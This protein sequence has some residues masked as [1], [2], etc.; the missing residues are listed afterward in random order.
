MR[1]NY[2]RPMLT[3]HKYWLG[4]AGLAHRL[5]YEI[6]I[7]RYLF[8]VAP[9]FAHIQY[10]NQLLYVIVLRPSGQYLFKPIPTS[11]PMTTEN[12][13]PNPLMQQI[14]PESATE[15]DD[16]PEDPSLNITRP[17]DP[18]R[19]RI[20]TIPALI[21]GIIKRIDHDEID[22][23]PEFQRK[24]RLWSL[25]NKSRLIESLL[26][27]IP[28]PVFYVAADDK[29]RWAV[30]DG[31]QRLTTIYDFVKNKFPLHGLEYL[32]Q[33]NDETFQTLPRTFQRRI[34]ETSLAMNLILDGTPEEVMINIFKRINTGGMPLTSQE[35]RNALNKGKV[36]DLL[37]N[38]ARS[39]ELTA[40]ATGP[41]NDGRMGAQELVLR[42]LAFYTQPWQEYVQNNLGLDQF[43]NSAMRRLNNLPANK[44]DEFSLVFRKTMAI[45]HAI[46]DDNAFRKPKSPDGYRSPINRALFEAWGVTLAKLSDEEQAIL[47]GKKQQ[48]R[49]DFT[50]LMANPIFNTAISS[51]T[52]ALARVTTRFTE[53]EHLIQNALK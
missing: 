47:I 50:Q 48:I 5:I 9:F 11:L 23:A 8:A 33:L 6:H 24:A 46:F 21:D 39:A 10:H 36:R 28:L 26:L 15:V 1:R 29:D 37:Q 17:F 51:S 52:G 13:Q 45:S 22:L 16:E 7:A 20:N 31:I 42:F 38:L 49:D 25:E 41:V 27:K 34:E 14:M 3:R 35:V 40:A 19:I 2:R 43:L 4:W 32:T 18:D 44:I 30:V 12:L 53:I